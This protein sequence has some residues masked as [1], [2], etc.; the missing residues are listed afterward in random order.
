MS[1]V[2]EMLLMNT[3]EDIVVVDLLLCRH[4]TIRAV[5]EALLQFAKPFAQLRK[6][7]CNSQNH[8][9]NC[10][11]TFAI[12]TTIHAVAE[13]LLQ[14]AKPLVQLRKCFC[15]IQNTSC[16]CGNA[17]VSS[18]NTLGNLQPICFESKSK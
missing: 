2:T 12:C 3:I 4:R 5:A 9:C 1:A 15:N 7:F 11:N 6:H 18:Q 13:T 17:F 8:S 16:S 10:G 14:F